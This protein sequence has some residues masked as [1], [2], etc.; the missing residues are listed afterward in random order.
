MSGGKGFTESWKPRGATLQTI[1]H[2]NEVFDEYR[3]HLPLTLRQVFYALVARHGYQKTEAGYK[4]LSNVLTNARR[5]GLVPMRYL[6]DDGAVRDGGGGGYRDKSE[7]LEDLKDSARYY[8]LDK[9]DDQ[10][11]QILV[12]V[13]SAGMARMVGDVC[14][15][16]SVPV[17]GVRGFSSLTEKHGLSKW[18]GRRLETGG[19]V[20][21]LGL[22][23]LDPS[24]VSLWE[25]LCAD[26]AAFLGDPEHLTF[27]RTLLTEEQAEAWNLESAPPK[28]TDSRSKAWGDR[29]TFQLEAV[30]PDVLSR[31]VEAAVRANLDLSV[32][33]ETL[34]RERREREELVEM[35][36]TLD[37]EGWPT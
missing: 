32:L 9:Q 1:E 37:L 4:R 17:L 34:E 35:L 14:E 27:T 36:G 19:E 24:G 8:C 25:D 12:V 11:I 10:P 15:P 31:T 21:L 20:A 29:P 30:P 18:V 23:D 3:D 6:R 16:Y 2:A 22:G 7:F 33:A 5:A 13:E 28:T 26:V